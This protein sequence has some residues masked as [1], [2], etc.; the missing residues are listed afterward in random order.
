MK[1]TKLLFFFCSI[2]FFTGEFFSQ[3]TLNGYG[4]STSTS[5]TPIQDTMVVACNDSVVLSV[6]GS[7]F[8]SIAFQETFNNGQPVGWNFS[9]TVTIANNTCGVPSLDN[10]DFMWMG[11]N[12]QHPRI[13]ETVDLDVSNGGDVCFEMRYAI[14]GQAAP[15]EGPDLA[16][17]GVYL[18][19]STNGGGTWTQMINGNY[20]AGTYWPPTNGG[21][22]GA[23]PLD[24][25]VWNAFCEQI[26]LA[27]QTTA[28]R[29]RWIQ[30]ATSNAGFDH[31]G[32]D[33]ISISQ[34]APS[35]TITWLHDLYSYGMGN[36]TGNNP[37]AVWPVGDTTFMV[38]MTDTVDTCYASVFVQVS[39]PQID[40]VIGINPTCGGINGSLGITASG[41]SA[42]YTYSIDSGAIFQGSGV[43]TQ[44]DTA[45][46][47]IVLVD[48]NGCSDTSV[49][50]LTGVDSLK[51]INFNSTH[52]SCGLDNG[53]I[54]FQS[55]G[56]TPTFIYS[57]ANS[58]NP[59]VIDTL[60]NFPNLIPGTYTV[61]VQDFLN[62]ADTMMV[63]IDPS[64]GP[65]IDS[66]VTVSESCEFE[67]GGLNAY[68][69]SGTSPYSYEITDSINFTNSNNT[70][71]FD[72]LNSGLYYVIVTDDV[73]CQNSNASVVDSILP[74]FAILPDSMMCNLTFQIN[75]VQTE[76]GAAWNSASPNISF[77]SS[78]TANPLITATEPG[79]YTINFSDTLCDYRGS[80]L[81]A[82]IADPYT[83]IEDTSV[84]IGQVY[85]LSTLE[86]DQNDT[87]TWNNG[88]IGPVTS[89]TE[90]GTYVVTASNMCGDYLDSA[91]ID[92]YL[93]DLETPNV[94]TPNGDNSNDN[95][96]LLF[97]SGI[98]TL[99]CVITNR[100]G[101][102]IKVFDNPSFEWDGTDE[103][104][105]EVPDGVYF[106]K[107]DA[108]TDGG[109]ELNKHGFVHLVRQ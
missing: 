93:C 71:V 62:C 95:F 48:Q 37:N 17:E 1:S 51:I 89:I 57:V 49:S 75:G 36:Y 60:G 86:Q 11:S 94:F 25:T 35:F 22:A 16:N 54:D 29:F 56:G 42:G 76:T 46:Y 32:L 68:I 98:A 73:G 106:Y 18:Q 15:C 104:G 99:T 88:A 84:C 107:V 85:P 7:G 34:A 4:S 33:N 27:A 28:T 105:N 50:I 72:N 83:E 52:T 26:P 20:P 5:G 12:S 41:G 80:F 45:L 55:T 6:S 53:L 108:V 102:V 90:S 19:Y 43:F 91:Y 3:C 30:T 74:P 103:K 92:F 82:F 23:T 77:S 64:S 66:I 39:F 67:N 2:I 78:S 10:S 100:W 44:L 14:Q 109:N 21:Q 61:V 63:T 96:H 47:N 97:Q 59:P 70:G 31:W 24:M 81:L 79:V 40:T 69:S 65:M 87:Y 8:G 58:T 101:N 38:M 13:M 9:Q